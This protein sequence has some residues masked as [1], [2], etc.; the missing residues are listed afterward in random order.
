VLNFSLS[1]T[2]TFC[3]RI[4]R[5]AGLLV[6]N[7]VRGAPE[8]LLTIATRSVGTHYDLCRQHLPGLPEEVQAMIA[9]HKHQGLPSHHAQWSICVPFCW[10]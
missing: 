10:F 9:R 7:L 6:D 8:S 4:L 3:V 2:H 1:C 5:L